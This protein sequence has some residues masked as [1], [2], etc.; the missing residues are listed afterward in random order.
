MSSPQHKKSRIVKPN[1]LLDE[2]LK[3]AGELNEPQ[4]YISS[5]NDLQKV[6]QSVNL[7][8]KIEKYIYS[9][10]SEENKLN[11][12]IDD[13]VFY[14]YFKGFHNQYDIA[15]FKSATVVDEEEYE[16][17]LF[18]VYKSSS[19]GLWRLAIQGTQGIKEYYDKLS[20]YVQT[21]LIYMELQLFLENEFYKPEN[22]EA[23]KLIDLPL[24]N[25]PGILLANYAILRLP[26]F[27]LVG[28]EGK[29]VYQV[30]M[31]Y[32]LYYIRQLDEVYKN[33]ITRQAQIL[34]KQAAYLEKV[35]Q[36]PQN[37]NINIEQELE[38]ELDEN[39]TMYNDNHKSIIDDSIVAFSNRFLDNDKDVLLKKL[40]YERQYDGSG[41]YIFTLLNF[42]NFDYLSQPLFFFYKLSAD[43]SRYIESDK[44][45]EFLDMMEKI[46]ENYPEPEFTDLHT[47]FIS[48]RDDLKEFYL[49]MDA[50]PE[51]ITQYDMLEK[52]IWVINTL[53]IGVF[54]F[55]KIDEEPRKIKSKTL[56][57][58]IQVDGKWKTS[59]R[60]RE[61]DKFP[62][63]NPG[64]ASNSD[65]PDDPESEIFTLLKNLQAARYLLKIKPG[66]PHSGTIFIL[67]YGHFSKGKHGKKNFNFPICIYPNHIKINKYGLPKKYISTGIYSGKPYDYIDQVCHKPGK[68]QYVRIEQGYTYLFCGDIYNKFWPGNPVQHTSNGASQSGG[69]RHKSRLI[70]KSSM[71][72]LKYKMRT[73]LRKY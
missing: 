1:N 8:T 3:L 55:R 14:L 61:Y 38:V 39:T 67:Y 10:G 64:S 58:Y 63:Q 72:K 9:P 66:M 54:D 7:M 60:K 26:S 65:N 50:K 43:Q 16:P 44:Y 18:I 40:D 71:K 22:I 34:E 28:T 70:L 21:T 17:Q 35:K 12:Q 68:I 45:G 49:E 29:S 6:E 37:R 33:L 25:I 41:N 27:N 24:G 32:I 15:I 4:D 48:I 31:A 42:I 56:K 57:K 23:K 69:S 52:L 73:P 53:M 11:I 46:L 62:A 59:F 47:L 19:Q 5:I 13:I 36:N 20:D 30:F 2:L 51:K